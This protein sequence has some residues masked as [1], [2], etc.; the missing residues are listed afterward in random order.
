MVFVLQQIQEDAEV[1]KTEQI[2]FVDLT[3]AFDTISRKGFWEILEKLGCPQK[4]LTMAAS[5]TKT[6]SVRLDMEVTSPSPSQCKR[7]E[8]RLSS[9]SNTLASMMLQQAM[10]DMD[11][12]DGMYIYIHVHGFHTDGSLFNFKPTPKRRNS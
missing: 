9:W 1:Q 7:C 11:D 2:T 10:E 3:K 5:F 8:T 6:S 12:D 4:F